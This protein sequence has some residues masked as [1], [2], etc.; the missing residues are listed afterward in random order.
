MMCASPRPVA[1]PAAELF[2]RMLSPPGAVLPMIVHCC[3]GAAFQRRM[4]PNRFMA[5]LIMPSVTVLDGT[6][7]VAAA[8]KVVTVDASAAVAKCIGPSECGAASAVGAD[9]SELAL[10]NSIAATVEA[11]A[12]PE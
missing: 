10:A 7:P 3:V 1:P 2:H 11:V 9:A 6:G 4:P 8:T 12:L 5:R